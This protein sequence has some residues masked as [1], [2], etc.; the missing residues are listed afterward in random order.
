[1]TDQA[2]IP[3]LCRTC[4]APR[5]RG[6]D[7]A[8][9]GAKPKRRNETREL[10]RPI[11][12]ALNAM[13]G[14]RVV[15]NN[16]GTLEWAPGKRLTYGLGLGSADLVGICR[17]AVTRDDA[18]WHIGRVFALEIKRPGQKL[19]PDQEKWSRVVRSLGGFC[20]VVH[21]VEEA[22]AAVARCR[23]GASE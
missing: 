3:L 11:E 8:T 13:P 15:R 18:W 19:R 22:I 9:C 23:A 7:C 20:C 21:S 12:A 4:G 5:S 6:K 16:V 1:M 17:V 14:V 10:T 2:S